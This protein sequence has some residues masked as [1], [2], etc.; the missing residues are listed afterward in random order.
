MGQCVC[1]PLVLINSQYCINAQYAFYLCVFVPHKWCHSRAKITENLLFMQLGNY[2]HCITS[3]GTVTAK[4]NS[5]FSFLQK[6]MKEI[7]IESMNNEMTFSVFHHSVK[8]F[9]VSVAWLSFSKEKNNKKKKKE[10]EN[11]QKEVYWWRKCI[12]LAFSNRII[13][14]EQTPFFGKSILS[15]K[16]CVIRSVCV[17]ISFLFYS[18]IIAIVFHRS[19]KRKRRRRRRRIS[20]I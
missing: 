11:E 6:S 2:Q 14:A 10:K 19:S 3:F 13:F 5:R 12:F 1:M 4:N 16:N 17:I 15:S 7:I 8:V 9:Q 20:P 18:I